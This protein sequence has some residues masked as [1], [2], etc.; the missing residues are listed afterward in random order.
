LGYLDIPILNVRAW[1]A[2]VHLSGSRATSYKCNGCA[3]G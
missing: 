3:R 1:A 2:L